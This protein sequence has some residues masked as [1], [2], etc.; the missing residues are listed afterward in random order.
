MGDR[1]G[2]PQLIRGR[3]QLLYGGMGRLS[4]SSVV[5]IRNK[6]HA[7]TCEIVVPDGGGS[8][9]RGATAFGDAVSA[10]RG[11]RVTDLHARCRTVL[12]DELGAVGK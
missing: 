5:N 3:T 9:T 2:R 11:C 4:E 12:N 8:G 7:V 6:S 10:S 1:A